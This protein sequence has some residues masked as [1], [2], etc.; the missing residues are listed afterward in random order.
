MSTQNGVGRGV[1]KFWQEFAGSIILK[2]RSIVHFCGWGKWEGHLLAVFCG[3]HIWV[4][5]ETIVI[6]KK[7]SFGIKTRPIFPQF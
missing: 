7:K 1:L 3:C 4:T 6:S 5:S 2:N